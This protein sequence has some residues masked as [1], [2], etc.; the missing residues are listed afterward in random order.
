MIKYRL[1][2]IEEKRRE[3]QD[4]KNGFTSCASDSVG[5]KGFGKGRELQKL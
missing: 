1:I 4:L 5:G 3:E 2:R